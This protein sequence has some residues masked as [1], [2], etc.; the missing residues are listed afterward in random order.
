MKSSAN[1][2]FNR[3]NDIENRIHN[4][5]TPSLDNQGR[6]QGTFKKQSF[7]HPQ[8]NTLLAYRVDDSFTPLKPNPGR[9]RS[10]QELTLSE[11]SES[12]ET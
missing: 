12:K 10:H 4:T 2:S 9:L 11:T 7:S 5:K 1:P 8:Q 6:G 3:D